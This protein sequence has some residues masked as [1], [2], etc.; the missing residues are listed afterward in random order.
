MIILIEFL[1][2]TDNMKL[3]YTEVSEL[4]QDIFFTEP[5][6]LAEPFKYFIFN[7]KIG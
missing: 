5:G 1:I 2:T 7:E 6:I 4:F 3:F